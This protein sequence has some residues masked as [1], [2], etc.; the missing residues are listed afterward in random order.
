MLSITGAMSNIYKAKCVCD[1]FVSIFTV[2]NFGAIS[3][4]K[5]FLWELFVRRGGRDAELLT[6]CNRNSYFMNA[7]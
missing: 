6:V 1:S 5:K 2:K 3:H 4:K 7:F